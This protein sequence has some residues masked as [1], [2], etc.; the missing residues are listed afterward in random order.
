VQFSGV[1]RAKAKHIAKQY[2]IDPLD[3]R[4]PGAVA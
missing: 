2:L 4:S 1:V 3:D